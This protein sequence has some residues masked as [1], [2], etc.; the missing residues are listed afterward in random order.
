V[1]TWVIVCRKFTATPWH[2][3]IGANRSQT[4]EGVS[5]LKSS[6]HFFKRS[7]KTEDLIKKED[8]HG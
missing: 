8:Q 5:I 7:K 6:L 4:N 1:A 2:W 3:M